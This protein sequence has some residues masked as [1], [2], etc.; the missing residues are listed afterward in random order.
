[1]RDWRVSLRRSLELGGRKEGIEG[2]GAGRR[3]EGGR[4]IEAM[5]ER[6]ER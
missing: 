4:E 5:E 3:R 1:M 6:T 2:V